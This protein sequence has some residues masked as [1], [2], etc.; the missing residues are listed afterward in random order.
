MN[1]LDEQRK[2]VICGKLFNPDRHGNTGQICANCRNKF[3]RK[4]IKQKA[5]KYKGGKCQICGYNKI[6]EALEFH[7]VN[8]SEKSFN[9]TA[10]NRS[11]QEIQDELEKCILLCANCHREIHAAM[12]TSYDEY[13]KIFDGL[14]NKKNSSKTKTCVCCGKEFKARSS[15]Q[16]CCSKK[17]HEKITRKVKRPDTYKDF[18]NEMD[19][20]KWNY[21]AMGRKY[22]V[23]SNTIKKWEKNYKM[24]H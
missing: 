20:L 13:M 4:K 11:W 16:K 15:K 5:V 19:E 2:C 3:H 14:K 6:P 21:S 22:G 10:T 12:E 23:A 7:H 9:I 8:P 18:K 24:S 1:S 17:C